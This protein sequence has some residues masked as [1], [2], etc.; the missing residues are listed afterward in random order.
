MKNK[1]KLFIS[2]LLAA[3]V[4]LTATSCGNFLN[5][6]KDAIPTEAVTEAV[7]E[8]PTK[9]ATATQTEPPTENKTVVLSSYKNKSLSSA[10]SELEDIG[11]TVKV[12]YEYSDTVEQGNVISQSIEEGTKVVLPATITLTL[13]TGKENTETNPPKNESVS[14]APS[15]NRVD[16][17]HYT[18]AVPD[19][20]LYFSNEITGEVTFYESY[21]YSKGDSHYGRLFSICFFKSEQE[22]NQYINH[23]RPRTYLIG[24]SNGL[25]F[26][27]NLPTD[28]Q[29][30]SDS[31]SESKYKSAQGQIQDVIAS[32]Q[33]S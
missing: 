20:W 11:F 28:V 32:M 12:E 23:G 1:L 8:T 5:L 4:L 3:T 31:T 26:A 30:L 17:Y 19:G 7:T 29:F 16:F 13:S 22:M 33:F 27:Y 10:K 18:I 9:A 25:Y 21:N 15:Q 14:S 6:I 24:V 2:A